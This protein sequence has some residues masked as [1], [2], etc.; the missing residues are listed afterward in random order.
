MLPPEGDEEVGV[1]YV[2]GVSAK[3]GRLCLSSTDDRVGDGRTV[4][5]EGRE[6]AAASVGDFRNAPG[7]CAICAESEYKGDARP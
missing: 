4:G 6:L 1:G 2:N 7:P 5:W 3:A